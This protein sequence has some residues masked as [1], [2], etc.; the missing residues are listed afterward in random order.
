[1]DHYSRS[2]L[3]TFA[4][5]VLNRKPSPD[6]P[7]ISEA[8]ERALYV[9]VKGDEI[10]FDASRHEPLLLAPP[11]LGHC[12]QALMQAMHLGDDGQCSYFAI[13]IERLSP[14]ATNCLSS[15]GSFVPLR[16][17]AAILPNQMAALL[18]YAR[19]VAGWHSLARF[20]SLCGH[21]TMPK[22]GSLAQA[23][24]NPDCG[25]QH[26]PRVDPAMIVLIHHADSDGDKC[27]LGRQTAWKPRVYSAISGYVEPGESAEDAVL[28]EVM[29]ETGI[30]VTDVRYFSSQPWPFS[31]S[32]MLG[33][34]A[35]AITTR[36][37]LDE[38]ELEDA[39][40]FSRHEIPDLLASGEFVLP[41]TE[42]IARHLFDAWYLGNAS[43]RD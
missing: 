33:F 13:N 30:S 7:E 4:G 34:H 15:L 2:A 24:T 8:L 40:W 42:T 6:A 20:C 41:S 5:L 11:M 21:P 14:G 1:M 17:H 16:Q 36:I 32:L 22:P 10:L 28:R 12:D 39:R 23:C 9:V 35:R 37:R 18:G 25:A 31:G 3:N 27:L 43:H 26:F 19:S 29:E 38:T